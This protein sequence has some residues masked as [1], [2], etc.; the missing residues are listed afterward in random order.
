MELKIS[1][2]CPMAWSGLRGGYQ[3]RFCSKCQL[4]VYNLAAMPD[5]EVERLVLRS[6]GRLCGR[7]YVRG[8]RTAT[9]RDCPESLIRR[10]SKLAIAVMLLLLTSAACWILRPHQFLDRRALPPLFRTIAD[11]IDREER[12]RF[13]VGKMVCPPPRIPPPSP[14]APPQTPP[15]GDAS[16]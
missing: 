11:W 6:E 16:Q 9:V 5:D 14:A 8:D 3:V 13:I 10:K 2:P 4:K 7:L 1:S 15:S 12:Q